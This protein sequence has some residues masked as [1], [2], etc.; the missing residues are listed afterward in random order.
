MGKRTPVTDQDLRHSSYPC[1]GNH[2]QGKERQNQFAVWATCAR[3]GLRLRY[4]SK[5]GSHG[6]D[7]QFAVI[8]HLHKETL[9]ELEKTI[10]ASMCTER[11][12]EGKMMELKG[13]MLQTGMTATA[14]R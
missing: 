3:C 8:P 7:R 5:R 9:E 10:P 6:N 14:R 2:K 12:V 11:L 1:Y 13:K 4:S